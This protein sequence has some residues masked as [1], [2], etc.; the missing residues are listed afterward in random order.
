[1]KKESLLPGIF[2]EDFKRYLSL[3]SEKEKKDFWNELKVKFS[4]VSPETLQ[5]KLREGILAVS[6]RIESLDQRIKAKQAV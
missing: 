3:D 4:E 6:S 5:K 1:M 2:E